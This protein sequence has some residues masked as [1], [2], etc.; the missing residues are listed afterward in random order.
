MY[1]ISIFNAHSGLLHFIEETHTSS[2]CKDYQKARLNAF[3]VLYILA[4]NF[5]HIVSEYSSTIS[6]SCVKIACSMKIVSAYEKEQALKIVKL[7]LEKQLF[8]GNVDDI[9]QMYTKLFN[10]RSLEKSSTG[11]SC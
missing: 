10:C 5:P 8:G 11:P 1:I 6:A 4:N 7:M 9:V 3:K 2:N